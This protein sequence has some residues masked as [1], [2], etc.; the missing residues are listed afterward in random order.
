MRYIYDWLKKR[1]G[2]VFYG[3]IISYIMV[4][5]IPIIIGG[6]AWFVLMNNFSTEVEKIHQAVLRQVQITVDEQLS[7]VERM[8]QQISINPYVQQLL[9][10]NPPVNAQINYHMK[11]ITSDIANT[12][13]VNHLIIDD[14]YIY[15]QNAQIILNSSSKLSPG[16][17]YG[18]VTS[19]KG[20]EYEA[21]KENILNSGERLMYLQETVMTQ[22]LDY[23]SVIISRLIESGRRN[24]GRL[25]IHLK[26]DYLSSV[27]GGIDEINRSVV[28][29][30][31]SDG[32]LL[33][34]NTEENKDI[35]KLYSSTE[36]TVFYNNESWSVETTDSQSLIPGLRYVIF[37]PESELMIKVNRMRNN[38]LL[39]VVLIVLFG[40]IFIVFFAKRN[41]EPIK[42]LIV[43][44]ERLNS[45]KNVEGGEY[46]YIMESLR[47]IQEEKNEMLETIGVQSEIV[48]ERFFIEVLKGNTEDTV[49][50][51]GFDIFGLDDEAYFQVIVISDR[52]KKLS[53]EDYECVKIAASQFADI[54]CARI[55]EKIALIVSFD[56]Y[57]YVN[58]IGIE[59]AQK[60]HR[61]L[62][63]LGHDNISIGIGGVQSGY[64]NICVSYRQ[65]KIAAERTDNAD[66]SGILNY[67]DIKFENRN[68]F[69][70]P[71]EIEAR[72]L[73][74]IKNTEVEAA[75]RLMLEI[76]DKNLDKGDFCDDMQ[77]LFVYDIIATVGRI[78]SE[79]TEDGT[80]GFNHADYCKRMMAAKGFAEFSA[81]LDEFFAE[82]EACCEGRKIRHSE[83]L[84]NR[85]TGYI[86]EHYN[87][88]SFSLSGM[89]E[90]FNI[91]PSYLSRYFKECFGENFNSYVSRYKIE[92]AKQMLSD[93]NYAIKEIS[94]LVGY[95][96]VNNFIKTF[97]RIEGVTPGQYRSNRA[98]ML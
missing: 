82:L 17:F 79:I 87:Q 37:T 36:D 46:S 20:I 64:M 22:S 62:N 81:I 83:G 70:Y 54:R 24:R 93:T 88:T 21:W 78:I 1:H 86:E 28:C 77:T 69:Y 95:W 98:G 73:N 97:K 61:K 59:L 40:G 80:A 23:D 38:I 30:T 72:I 3:F 66:N 55:E 60:I 33:F 89:A 39:A 10:A 42:N 65:A 71:I 53:G 68:G 56:D 16:M 14:C 31:D 8:S 45:K 18:Y 57:N 15:F 85:I 29:I 74:Y 47:S 4:I 5:F 49:L 11:D 94:A 51:S 25:V 50:G 84:K 6:C 7:G 32:Q 27:I 90:Y 96:D 43:N 19:Y 75:K 48:R 92:K 2:R 9:Q 91:T 76:I 41:Y 13:A 44:L 26:K 12:K 35:L 63:M 52:V 58:E 67:H 34:A